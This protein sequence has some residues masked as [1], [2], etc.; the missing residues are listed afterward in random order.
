MYVVDGSVLVDINNK[1]D[2]ATFKI[3]TLPKTKEIG[4]TH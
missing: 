2:M 3:D 4:F 1:K